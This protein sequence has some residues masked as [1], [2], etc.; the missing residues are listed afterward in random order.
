ML[1]GRQL[2]PSMAQRAGLLEQFDQGPD[3]TP[4][5]RRR[6]LLPQLR[7]FPQQMH[8]AA[9]LAAVDGVVRGVEIGHQHARQ[10]IPQRFADHRGAA[11][12]VDQQHRQVGIREAPAPRVFAVDPP[13]GLVGVHHRR[14]TQSC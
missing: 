6:K 2:V 7:Q 10:R 5:H 9:L 11:T 14:L 12:M 4:H 13:A 1:F 8:Q 3:V